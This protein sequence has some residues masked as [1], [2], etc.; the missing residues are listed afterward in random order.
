MEYLIIKARQ[1]ALDEGTLIKVKISREDRYE[2]TKMSHLTFYFTLDGQEYDAGVAI[3]DFEQY[4]TGNS[5]HVYY[6]KGLKYAAQQNRKIYSFKSF[7]FFEIIIFCIGIV[8]IFYS[9][10]INQ[11]F[12]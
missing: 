12:L 2:T 5:I 4:K 11:F 9:F 10:I 1:R 7:Y 6:I 8:L 3:R